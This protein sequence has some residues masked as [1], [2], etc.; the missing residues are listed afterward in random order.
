MAEARLR[1]QEYLLKRRMFRRMSTGQV[2]ERDRRT[3]GPEAWTQFSYPTPVIA[4]SG[5]WAL[6]PSPRSPLPGPT[7]FRGVPPSG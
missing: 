6:W 7:H 2:T 1:G 5:T 4:G 3:N